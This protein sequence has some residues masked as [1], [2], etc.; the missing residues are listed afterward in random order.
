MEKVSNKNMYQL[1]LPMLGRVD[2]DSSHSHYFSTFLNGEFYRKKSFALRYKVYCEEKGF[3]SAD[4]FPKKMEFDCYDV[5]SKHFGLFCDEGELLGSVRLVHDSGLGFPMEEYWGD[6][7]PPHLRSST[8][9]IS[10]LVLCKQRSRA[11]RNRGSDLPMT[12]Q[13]YSE[14]YKSIKEN[15]MTHVAAAMEPSLVRL[16]R[17]FGLQFQEIGE[18]VNYYGLVKL[19][20]LT[21]DEFERAISQVCP[22]VQSLFLMEDDSGMRLSA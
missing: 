14:I 22:E 6:A 12:L 15:S 1:P 16:L 21:L 10:R 19:Y 4:S 2:R 9:E 18:E 17:R 13:L 5:H 11:G 8:V 7:I 20:M 3:L